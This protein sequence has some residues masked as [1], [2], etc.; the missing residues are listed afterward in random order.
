MSLIAERPTPHP[1]SLTSAQVAAYRRDG[2]LF[3]IPVMSAAEAAALRSRLEAFERQEGRPLR[4]ALRHKSHLLFPW[5]WDLIHHPRILDAVEDLMGPNLLCWSSSFFIKEANDPHFV[6]WHQDSTYWG[7]SEPE[8]V[9][10]WV[11]LSP[12]TIASGAMKV[13]PGSHGEQVAHTDTYDENNLLTRGQEIAVEV[14]Q[15][16]AVDMPL[17]PGQM[18]LHHVRIFHGSEP[19]RSDDRRIGFAIRYIPTHVRQVIGPKDGAVLVRGVDNFRNFEP[20][21]APDGELSPG[22]LAAHKAAADRQAAILYAGTQ[23]TSFEN[24]VRR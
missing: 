7:L 4:G 14:D 21:P 5:L 20:E 16:K 3:P 23:T 12:S 9:T 15:S 8:I 22:A 6:S 11:A 13:I 24:V 18:S 2:Y 10:A 19:N 1:K 17:D